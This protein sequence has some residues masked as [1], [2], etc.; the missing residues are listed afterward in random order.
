MYCT[1]MH[2]TVLYVVY[3]SLLYCTVRNIAQKNINIIDRKS[4]KYNKLQ[5][6]QLLTVSVS[7]MRTMA[8]CTVLYYIAQYCTVLQFTVP[9]CT[10][11]YGALWHYQTIKKISKISN[12]VNGESQMVVHYSTQ[13]VHY[14]TW[15]CTVLYCRI[16]DQ[17]GLRGYCE[18]LPVSCYLGSFVFAVKWQKL[19]KCTEPRHIQIYRNTG[20]HKYYISL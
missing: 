15:Y 6:Y 5:N 2:C 11:L 16:T 17:M 12:A 4:E 3:C 19:C 10:V 7:H 20:I 9:Y 18:I 1:V 13:L 14:I 8:H